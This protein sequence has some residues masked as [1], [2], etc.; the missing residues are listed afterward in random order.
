MDAVG[1]TLRLVIF[2]V[3]SRRSR[4]RVGAPQRHAASGRAVDPQTSPRG[5][6]APL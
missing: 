4:E 6:G 5:A 1:Q 3:H 2:Y